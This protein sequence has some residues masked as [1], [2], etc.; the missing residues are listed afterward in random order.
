MLVRHDA[1]REISFFQERGALSA[2]LFGCR[3][4]RR[5]RGK[6]KNRIA[7]LTKTLKKTQGTL[8][9]PDASPAT[10]ARPRA[11]RDVMEKFTSIV[12]LIPELHRAHWHTCVATNLSS[13]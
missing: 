11:R 1:A 5:I 7:R 8:L 3:F 2:R 4:S 10:G 13:S 12:I 6:I 9:L